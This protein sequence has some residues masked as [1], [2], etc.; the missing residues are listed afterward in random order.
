MTQA[1][2]FPRAVS[3]GEHYV[4]HSTEIGADADTV[5]GLIADVTRWPTIF[6][7]TVHVERRG[8]ERQETLQMWAFAHNEVRSWESARD[9]DPDSR[10]VMFHQTRPA[11]PVAAMSGMWE[12]QPIGENRVKAVLRHW[13]RSVDDDPGAVE[14]IESACDRNSRAELDALKAAAEIAAD[15]DELVLDFTDEERIAAEPPAVFE[16]LDR[17]ELWSTLLP[18]VSRSELAE[19][20]PG[21][22]YLTMDTVAA[23]GSTHTTESVRVCL[24][25][26]RI[27]YKQVRT[28]AAMSAHV[29]L[30]TVRPDGS[31]G[32]LA[33]SRHVVVIR[34]DKVTDVL[35]PDG[36][37]AKARQM[38]RT[39]LGNN[40][41][42]TLRHARAATAPGS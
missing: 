42:T 39:S 34:P 4:V 33:T 8:D 23:D 2:T 6:P 32:T 14:L 7:P 31:G 9:L 26:E 28:P 19:P 18:H 30:W 35:G 13:Y 40:S 25:G 10:T 29:G 41:L 11:H 36:T 17:A 22:Q 15:A 12:V 1:Q 3:S 16:F 24:D 37:V 20:T 38:I 21:T 5:Y 27:A